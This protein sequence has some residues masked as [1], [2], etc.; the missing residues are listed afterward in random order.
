[1]Q[2]SLMLK[3]TARGDAFE[4][5]AMGELRIFLPGVCIEISQNFPALAFAIR[6][7]LRAVQYSIDS[8]VVK[9]STVHSTKKVVSIWSRLV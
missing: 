9:Y 2:Q 4:S 1:M 8:M 5:T 6:V 3:P 7:Q